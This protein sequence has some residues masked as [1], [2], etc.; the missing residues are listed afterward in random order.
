M[1]QQRRPIAK[2]TTR[3]DSRR[4]WLQFINTGALFPIEMF[5]ALPLIDSHASAVASTNVN[6]YEDL[7][8]GDIDC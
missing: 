3:F 8:A 2:W 7:S 1:E 4:V 5:R 6:Q